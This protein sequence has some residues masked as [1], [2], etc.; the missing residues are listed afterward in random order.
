M[1]RFRA[2]KGLTL[3]LAM[4][5][6]LI[7]LAGSGSAAEQKLETAIFAGGCFW[8]IESDFERVDGVVDAVSG[9]TGGLKKDAT[10]KVVSAG[11]TGHLEA[12]KITYDA[13]KISYERML[14]L[15]WRSIDPTDGGGQFCDRGDSYA[16]AVFATNDK[17]LELAR[18]SKT[19]LDASKVL[20]DPVVTPIRKAEPFYAAEAYHQDYRAKN[21]F[22]Y[23]F[24]RFSC[25]RDRRIRTLWGDDAWGG[26]GH[27]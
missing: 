23:K 27:S 18:A 22:K 12:V 26:K 8:C 7:G 17:Q 14:H 19:R 24:Y 3:A 25:G 10:Y 11:G 1:N 15:F 20:A 4:G 9:Y 5:G 21:S 16:T 2:I 13:N 6:V